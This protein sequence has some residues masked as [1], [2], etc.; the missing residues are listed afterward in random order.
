VGRTRG[1][2]LA[3]GG[4]I[5]ARH[6][7]ARAPEL[8]E[9]RA[10]PG[11]GVAGLMVAGAWLDVLDRHQAEKDEPAAMS[12]LDYVELAYLTGRYVPPGGA[13]G[14][15]GGLP[16]STDAARVLSIAYRERTDSPQTH[17]SQSVAQSGM[18]QGAAQVHL[19]ASRPRS[20][21]RGH[22]TRRFSFRVKIEG[23][24]LTLCI[25]AVLYGHGY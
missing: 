21:Q 20:V 2:F 13:A 8:L 3:G 11:G 24:G 15:S 1:T 23:E 9:V 10:A 7:V 14:L 16:P 12:P 17:Y 25:F 19:V 6:N 18:V 5:L 4:A 22:T